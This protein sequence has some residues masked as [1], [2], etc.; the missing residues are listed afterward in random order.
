MSS[1][2]RT[3]VKGLQW[4]P[5]EHVTDPRGTHV[6]VLR[7]Y[8][9][10]VN[11]AGEV[12]LFQGRKPQANRDYSIVQR[13]ILPNIRGAVGIVQIPLAFAPIDVGDY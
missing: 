9:W 10:V 13:G 7:D 3:G 11:D 5:V 6:Q 1:F 8:W 4:F 12:A 2:Q